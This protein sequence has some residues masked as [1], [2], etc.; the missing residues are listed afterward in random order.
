MSYRL[1]KE[2]QPV[3]DSAKSGLNYIEFGIKNKL[4]ELMDSVNYDSSFFSYFD[5]F[6]FF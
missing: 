1:K 5:F 6:F 3:C 2:M 4:A